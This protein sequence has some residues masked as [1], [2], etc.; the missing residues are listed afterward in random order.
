M[1]KFTMSSF[2]HYQFYFL[3]IIFPTIF[4]MKVKNGG[5]NALYSLTYREIILI[6]LFKEHAA[7]LKVPAIP[8]PPH[9]TP[10]MK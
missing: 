10:F 9:P 4:T 8:T 3:W 1:I 5:V 7:C 6:H 2:N